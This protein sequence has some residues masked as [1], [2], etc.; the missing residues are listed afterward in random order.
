MVGVILIVA[1]IQLIM[2]LAA[3]IMLNSILKFI[4]DGSLQNYPDTALSQPPFY[5]ADMHKMFVLIVKVTAFAGSNYM[6]C[7]RYTL[8][9]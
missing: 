8:F 5:P 4:Y 6:G 7:W 3:V 9:F 1:R 2:L